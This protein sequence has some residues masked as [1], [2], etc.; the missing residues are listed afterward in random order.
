M[1][2]SEKEKLEIDKSIK[3]ITEIY[4]KTCNLKDKAFDRYWSLCIPFDVRCITLNNLSRFMHLTCSEIK[5]LTRPHSYL[6]PFYQEKIRNLKNEFSDEIPEKT[7]KKLIDKIDD[8][9]AIRLTMVDHCDNPISWDTCQAMIIEKLLLIPLSYVDNLLKHLVEALQK[10]S[11]GFG[12]NIQVLLKENFIDEKQ[13]ECLQN[14]SYHRN[15]WMHNNGL[16]KDNNSASCSLTDAIS[17]FE[18]LIDILE[19]VLLNSKIKDF[20]YIPDK[21]AEQYMTQEV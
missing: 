16:M 1:H 19:K 8:I 6:A 3:K 9:F 21:A 4:K 5:Q 15:A 17:M 14:Y 10:D 13:R 18:K 20:P 7:W 11:K 2:Y 12:S